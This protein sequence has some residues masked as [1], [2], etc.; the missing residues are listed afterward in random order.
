MKLAMLSG[1]A[2]KSPSLMHTVLTWWLSLFTLGVCCVFLGSR[3]ATHT[4]FETLNKQKNFS[5]ELTRHQELWL[6]LNRQFK[7]RWLRPRIQ[8]AMA[9]RRGR[10]SMHETEIMKFYQ[11]LA[12][13]IRSGHLEADLAKKSFG[14]SFFAYR[15]AYKNLAK[16]NGSK[17]AALETDLAYLHKLW[18]DE[19]SLKNQELA[20]FFDK[21]VVP[22]T[23]IAAYPGEI[24]PG[25]SEE[26]EALAGIL[27]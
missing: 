7:T 15:Q 8:F 3:L 9:F 13:L 4:A 14:N 5:M 17:N 23:A 19:P 1:N 26:V 12:V 11:Q 16:T 18:G 22:S 6:T 24:T 10:L 21:E 20:E 25:T 27:S 2:M